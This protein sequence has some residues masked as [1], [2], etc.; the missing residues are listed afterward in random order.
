RVGRSW[1][2]YPAAAIDVLRQIAPP[3][4]YPRRL[5]P[6]PRLHNT[7][8][9]AWDDV[10]AIF[11]LRVVAVAAIRR[12]CGMAVGRGNHHVGHWN[13]GGAASDSFCFIEIFARDHAGI[14]DTEGKLRLAVIKHQ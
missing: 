8:G 3:P 6:T 13:S 4:P 7:V 11:R 14:H 10:G 5:K 1:P 2:H 9:D 12:G